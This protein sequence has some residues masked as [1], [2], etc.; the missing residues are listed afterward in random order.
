LRRFAEPSPTESLRGSVR[1]SREITG[2]VGIDAR[3]RASKIRDSS[4]RSRMTQRL[5]AGDKNETRNENEVAAN[6]WAGLLECAVF[7]QQRK[8]RKEA[9]DFCGERETPLA[10]C[11][12]GYLRGKTVRF[13]L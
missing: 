1:L 5:R 2:E 8:R 13:D 3:R 12:F 11:K 9:L 4:L 6:A 10:S 7:R